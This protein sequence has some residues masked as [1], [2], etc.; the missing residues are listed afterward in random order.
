MALSHDRLVDFDQAVP[1]NW[2]F[3]FRGALRHLTRTAAQTADGS[4]ALPPPDFKSEEVDS[5]SRWRQFEMHGYAIKS[6][7]SGGT[8]LY[9]F[10]HEYKSVAKFLSCS[11]ANLKKLLRREIDPYHSFTIPKRDGSSRTISA[12]SRKIKG[13]QKTILRK[14]L[15]RKDVA[16]PSAYAYVPGRS[17]V[18]C[19]RFHEGAKWLIKVDL[20]DFFG[21]ID[22]KKVFWSL[23]SRRLTPYQSFVLARLCTRVE[24]SKEELPKGKLAEIKGFETPNYKK[25]RATQRHHLA[26]KFGVTRR[27]I[28]YVPQGAS[29]SGQ[30][31]NLVFWDLDKYFS[32]L[33]Q[34]HRL[35]YTR[36]AD[37]IVFSSKSS[38]NR[39]LAESILQTVTKK[40][41]T[42]GFAINRSKTRIL[43]PGSRLRVLGLLVDEPGLRIPAENKRKVQKELRAI[44]VFG[45]DNHAEFLDED[46]MKVL[47]RIFGYLVWANQI[48][49]KWAMSSLRKLRELV[50]LDIKPA[51]RI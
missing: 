51:Y 21:S 15:S 50:D 44:E 12:P 11:K 32:E 46:R 34:T 38:F 22:E 30:I 5:M 25:Y 36:Y 26:K 17:A 41:Y 20:V 23:V 8:P 16:H 35:L 2:G 19:A 3:S 40:L 33:A 18:K 1:R 48:E 14:L 29:T 28:G 49:P 24:R 10:R 42:N 27:R 45:F 7:L 37:D 43:P 13:I 39:E 31:S 9:F 4:K 6:H 47:N